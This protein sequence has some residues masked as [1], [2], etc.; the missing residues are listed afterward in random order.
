MFKF[1]LNI[2]LL[3]WQWPHYIPSDALWGDL[4]KSYIQVVCSSLGAVLFV[5]MAVSLQAELGRKNTLKLGHVNNRLD[6]QLS[7]YRCGEA[8]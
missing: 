3:P 2:E 8:L 7:N 4:Q 1:Y 6:V 5:D